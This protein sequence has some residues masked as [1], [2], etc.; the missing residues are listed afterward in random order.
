MFDILIIKLSVFLS[1]FCYVYTL[2]EGVSC[3]PHFRVLFHYKSAAYVTSEIFLLS[4]VPNIQISPPFGW[5]LVIIEILVLL[6]SSYWRKRKIRN[7]C[8]L[9]LKEDMLQSHWKPMLP[10]TSLQLKIPEEYC[11]IRMITA[12]ELQTDF[13][14]DYRCND[15]TTKKISNK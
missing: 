3:A 2:V 10:W 5:C 9:I 1:V 11:L 6:Q 13:W 12:C 7:C 4:K 8:F 15:R 14:T